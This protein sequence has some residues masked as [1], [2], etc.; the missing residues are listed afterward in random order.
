MVTVPQNQEFQNDS[1]NLNKR[2]EMQKNKRR[3]EE[4]L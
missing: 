4:K 2:R 3:R 1:E